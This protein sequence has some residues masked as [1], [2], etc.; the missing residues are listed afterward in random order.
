MLPGTSLSA[1]LTVSYDDRYYQVK[2]PLNNH[3]DTGR[4]V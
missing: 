2:T 4:V 1:Y 3:C